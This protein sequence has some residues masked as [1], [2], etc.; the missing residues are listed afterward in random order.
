MYA[1]ERLIGSENFALWSLEADEMFVEA[2][3]LFASR[4]RERVD[5]AFD[6]GLTPVF[7][8]VG[9][10]L[11]IPPLMSPTAFDRYVGNV[12]AP[13]IE[14]IHE[15]GGYV[16]VHSHGKMGPVLERF[17]DMGVD[18]LNPIEPPPMGDITLAEAFRRVGNRMG[19][20]GNIET[21]DFM[22]G[23][24]DTLRPLIHDCIDEGR[25]RRYVL[26]PS[27]GFMENVDPTDTEIQN[28]M[29]YID[30]AVRYA[31]NP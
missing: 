28:W 16:W 4:L 19:L 27:S 8:W 2:I 12:D 5:D 13:L 10:E 23:T 31:Q 7:G 30:E 3:A 22:T 18:V 11:C 6:A 17:A 25:G 9:P 24:V 21:H 15:R 26:C 29:F 20:E 14:R 1:L